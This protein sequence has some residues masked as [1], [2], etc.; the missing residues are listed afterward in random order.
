VQQPVVVRRRARSP[1]AGQSEAALCAV[2]LYAKERKSASVLVS[3]LEQQA[4]L[5]SEMQAPEM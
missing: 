5:A 4:Q 1:E 2:F 3:G